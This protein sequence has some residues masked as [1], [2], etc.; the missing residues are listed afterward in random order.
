MNH[1]QLYSVLQKTPDR[2]EYTLACVLDG[3]CAGEQ[4]LLCQNRPCWTAGGT[5]LLLCGV[6]VGIKA[7]ALGF[8][9]IAAQQRL[10]DGGMCALHIVGGEMQLGHGK[11]SF[12][13]DLFPIIQ[14]EN[15]ECNGSIAG[16]TVF[17]PAEI[18]DIIILTMVFDR[19]WERKL[20]Y[21]KTH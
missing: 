17:T 20:N 18:R 2:G 21:G 12:L 3:C 7:V 6:A 1:V 5:D 11:D 19:L 10:E 13:T 9:Q 16:S 4:L 15:P 14:E 8:F